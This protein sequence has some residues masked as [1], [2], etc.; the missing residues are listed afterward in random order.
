[1]LYCNSFRLHFDTLQAFVVRIDCSKLT[2][3][4]LVNYQEITSAK[5][6]CLVRSKHHCA[7]VYVEEVFFPGH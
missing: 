2:W 7:T 6:S 1:M 5:R 4:F 3:E